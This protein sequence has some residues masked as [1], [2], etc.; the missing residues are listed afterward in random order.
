MSGPATGM[1]RGTTIRSWLGTSPK[2]Q[3]R[4]LPRS[5]QALCG[6][7]EA[8]CGLEDSPRRAE[9]QQPESQH[10]QVPPQASSR[11]VV[12]RTGSRAGR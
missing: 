3:G 4:G 7:D 11:T 5:V 6:P 1:K 2:E 8:P 10:G 9:P 12:P